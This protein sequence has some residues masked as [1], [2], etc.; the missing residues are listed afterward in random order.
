MKP[1]IIT[2]VLLLILKV[3]ETTAENFEY[4]AKFITS[5]YFIDKTDLLTELFLKG[6]L[7]YR[8]IMCPHGFGKSTNLAMVRKFS[9]IELDQNYHPIHWRR[10]SAYSLFKHLKIGMDD[11]IVSSHLARYP[12]IFINMSSARIDEMI[13]ENI[14]SMM[15]EVINQPYKDYEWLLD[16]HEKNRS[17]S[18]LN[19]TDIEFM[20]KALNKHL[21]PSEVMESLNVLSR[22]LYNHFDKEV[23]VLIDDLDKILMNAFINSQREVTA[24]KYF[25]KLISLTIDGIFEYERNKYVGYGLLAGVSGLLFSISDASIQEVLV[26]THRFLEESKFAPFFG[27]T[28]K[29]VE[30]LCK[31]YHCNKTMITVLQNHFNGYKTNFKRHNLYHPSSIVKYFQS[32]NN[33]AQFPAPKTYWQIQEHETFIGRFLGIPPYLEKISQLFLGN[34]VTFHFKRFHHFS[35]VFDLL[36]INY[37]KIHTDHVDTLMT[38]LFEQGLLTCLTYQEHEAKYILP[39]EQVKEIFFNQLLDFYDKKGIRIETIAECFSEVLQI[40]QNPDAVTSMA[41]KIQDILAEPFENIQLVEASEYSYCEEP[42][43][44]MFQAVIYASLLKNGTFNVSAEILDSL[45][46]GTHIIFNVE[47]KLGIILLKYQSEN[48][49]IPIERAIDVYKR[50]NGIDA[51]V[52]IAINIVQ[53]GVELTIDCRNQLEIMKY[54]NSTESSM[55]S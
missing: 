9:Q 5:K 53:N 17:F 51:M 21:A 41:Q 15:N 7:P 49:E 48:I 50:K 2:L 22:I 4:D 26:Y 24:N 52:L 6:G 30:K 33:S 18:R 37:P 13:N 14:I 1:P 19:Q 16:F 23:I 40:T 28:Q 27:F 38:F 35:F 42:A 31:R 55:K 8:Y 32:V 44:V 36:K 29:E 10:S 25:V 54:I 43:E 11:Y 46:D 12:V 3:I 20:R 45:T 34:P 47:N 39:N